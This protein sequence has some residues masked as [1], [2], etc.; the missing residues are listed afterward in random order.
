MTVAS[1]LANGLA[2]P[3][4]VTCRSSIARSGLSSPPTRSLI[5]MPRRRSTL[6]P[7]GLVGLGQRGEDAADVVAGRGV[8]RNGDR[9]RDLD[10]LAGLDRDAAGGRR[11]P[12][13]RSPIGLLVLGEQVEL[14]RVGGEAVGGV[15]GQVERR[16]AAVGDDHGV[17]DRAAGVDGVAVAGPVGAVAVGGRPDRPGDVAVRRQRGAGADA[18]GRDGGEQGQSGGTDERTVVFRRVT[19]GACRVLEVIWEGG[20]GG[21]A[22]ARRCLPRRVERSGQL[23]S[24]VIVR[25]AR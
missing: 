9:E 15:H 12:R 18:D 17:L 1:P 11:A 20:Q 7:C 4:Y 2:E 6:M 24:A 16:R 23:L 3:A 14:A 8:V 22:G 5:R 19:D 25:V 21:G 13:R 10:G